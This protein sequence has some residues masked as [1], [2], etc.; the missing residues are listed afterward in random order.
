[1]AFFEASVVPDRR[2]HPSLIPRCGACGLHKTCISPKMPVTGEGKLGILVIAE[3]P[4]EEEDEKNEQFIGPAG[5]VLRQSLQKFGF[6]LDRD[7]W[8]TNALICRPENNKTPTPDQIDYCRPNLTNTINKLKPRVI[9]P[10]GGAAVRSL[11]GPY[12][13]DDPGKISQWVGWQIPLQK[14]NAWV[15]PTYHPSYVLRSEKEREGAVIKLWFERHLRAAFELEGYPWDV[16]PDYRRQIKIVMD[17]D[18]A[19]EW[20]RDRLGRGG[21]FSFDY[22]TNRLKPDA[23]NAEIICCSICWAGAET[24]AY[25]WVGEAIQATR[26]FVQSDVKKIG[27]N[28]KF[29]SRWSRR[30][31]EVGVKNWVWDTMQCAHVLDC[32]PGIT[33]VK[34]QGFVRLGVEDWSANMKAYL[35]DTRED[36]TNRIREAD[37][38]SLLL[39]CGLDSL[40]EFHIAVI[41]KREMEKG[42]PWHD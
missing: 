3:A 37:L 41:Q 25:P 14:L 18:E 27:A 1:M 42:F 6:D 9:V 40:I 32:R 7:C 20:I 22:E 21:L 16:V 38:R 4:G 5:Q 29:E 39:Y 28:N 10:M 36:G 33:S 23:E 31:L 17:P 35:H 30:I 26:E 34:F 24:I 15:T 8:K 19:A 13:R 12:W 2:H 11:L